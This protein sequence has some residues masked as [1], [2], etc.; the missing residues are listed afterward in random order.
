MHHGR[1]RRRVGWCE[2]SARLSRPLCLRCSTEGITSAFVALSLASLSVT[3]TRGGRICRFSSLRSKR[4]AAG[5]SRR[6]WTRTSSTTPSWSTARQSQCFLPAILTST[7]SRCHMVDGPCSQGDDIGLG[8]LIACAHMSGL[9]AR[10]HMSA[11]QGG[12]AL[13]LAYSSASFRQGASSCLRITGSAGDVT[14]ISDRP[15]RS[16]S[17]YAVLVGGF[18]LLIVAVYLGWVSQ[19]DQLE[20]APRD[21]DLSSLRLRLER[22]VRLAAEL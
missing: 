18:V 1:S 12:R 14:V 4:L 9:L 17:G 8:D 21:R 19:Q 6:L 7:S 15:G 10:S 16:M 5:L 3:M 13:Y 20:R 11:G 22:A 2:F